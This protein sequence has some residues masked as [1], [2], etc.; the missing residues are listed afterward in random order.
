MILPVDK[1]DIDGFVRQSLRRPQAAESTT[2][3]HNLWLSFHKSPPLSNAEINH[4]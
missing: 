2:H 1:H 4:G 3:D